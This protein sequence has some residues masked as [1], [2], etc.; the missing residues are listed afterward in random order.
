MYKPTYYITSIQYVLWYFLYCD[1][2]P[3]QELRLVSTHIAPHVRVTMY[4]LC[5]ATHHNKGTLLH[6]TKSFTTSHQK[7][8]LSTKLTTKLT[9]LLHILRPMHTFFVHILSLYMYV[10]H[11]YLKAFIFWRLHYNHK[12]SEHSTTILQAH[13][14]AIMLLK[15]SCTLVESRADVSM[16]AYPLVSVGGYGTCMY[17]HVCSIYSVV[18][19]FACW[20]Y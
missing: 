9:Q 16:K 18:R 13:S 8:S 6:G 14:P 1:I 4:V 12:A 10:V 17:V 3:I 5:Y 7:H 11:M 15:A 19:L 20:Y 2:S